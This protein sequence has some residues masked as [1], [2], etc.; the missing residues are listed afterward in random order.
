[1]TGRLQQQFTANAPV[2]LPCG[3]WQSRE[4]L[5]AQRQALFPGTRNHVVETRSLFLA[6]FEVQQTP[7]RPWAGLT[8]GGCR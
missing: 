2:A 1:M 7:S 6:W 8:I 4:A 5:R 3:S